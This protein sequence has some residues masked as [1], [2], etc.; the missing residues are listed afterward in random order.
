M[1]STECLNGQSLHIPDA[2]LVYYLLF[3]IIKNNMVGGGNKTSTIRGKCLVF[4][5]SPVKS[6][7]KK[8]KRILHFDYSF[9]THMP[10]KVDGHCAFNW[11]KYNLYCPV[12]YHFMNPALIRW[13]LRTSP[14]HKF[15][16]QKY[17]HRSSRQI[18][19][20]INQRCRFMNVLESH[21]L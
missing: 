19:N 1:Q 13:H 3:S 4:R 6:L 17:F 18:Q 2:Q 9:L 8:K 7:K 14:I 10:R 16:K 20:P 21:L 12:P 11:F 5:Q 15:I